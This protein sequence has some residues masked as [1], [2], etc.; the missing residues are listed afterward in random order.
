MFSYQCFVSILLFRS[1]GLCISPSWMGVE[2]RRFQCDVS[3][4]S[5]KAQFC[6]GFQKKTDKSRASVRE[7]VPCSDVAVSARPMACQEVH[8]AALSAEVWT[9]V[10]TVSLGTNWRSPKTEQ[11]IAGKLWAVSCLHWVKPPVGWVC[12]EQSMFRVTLPRLYPRSPG[13]RICSPSRFKP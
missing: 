3:A 8:P 12:A 13:Q 7:S 10:Q 4:I 9:E 5:V 2:I 6:G 11:V 1:S